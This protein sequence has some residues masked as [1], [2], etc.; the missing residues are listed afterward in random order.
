M[1]RVRPDEL[2]D[3]LHALGGS[4]KLLAYGG[5]YAIVAGITD[6]RAGNAH[7]HLSG[8]SIFEHLHYLAAGGATHNAVIHHDDR[9][10]LDGGA[11]GVELQFHRRV[12][13]LLGGLNKGAPYI[14]VLD[15]PFHKG[16]A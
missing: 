16:N 3:F 6:G 8:S 10:A 15:Q 7:M 13:L 9:L 12:P 1:Q 11:D 4:D 2:T 14:A 5:I